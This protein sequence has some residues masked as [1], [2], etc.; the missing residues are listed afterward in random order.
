V[1][2][3]AVDPLGNLALTCLVALVPVCLL[4]VLLAVVRVTAWGRGAD[5]RSR[6]LPSRHPRLEN[7]PR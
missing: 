5:R 1:F 4:L 6:H 2:T 3:Q 7:A